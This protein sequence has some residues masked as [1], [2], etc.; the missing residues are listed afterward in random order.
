MN[1]CPHCHNVHVNDMEQALC[2][3]RP[4]QKPLMIVQFGP[5]ATHSDYRVTDR[6]RYLREGKERTGIVLWVV[7][8]LASGTHIEPSEKLRY[9]VEPFDLTVAFGFAD[10]AEEV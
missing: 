6:I 3:L 9:I 7:P 2:P 8:A 4:E 10:G 5:L 1:S